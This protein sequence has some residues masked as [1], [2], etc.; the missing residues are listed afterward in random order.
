MLSVRYLVSPLFVPQCQRDVGVV[1]LGP[2]F[3]AICLSSWLLRELP[4]WTSAP[5]CAL[6][7]IPSVEASVFLCL[8]AFLLE[9]HSSISFCIYKHGTVQTFP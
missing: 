7:P 8:L 5:T 6:N 9:V 3:V 1:C 4:F 2:A